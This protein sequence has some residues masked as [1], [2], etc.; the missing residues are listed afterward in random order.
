M[1]G[2]SAKTK[3]VSEPKQLSPKNHNQP[4]RGAGSFVRSR[5]SNFKRDG[6]DIDCQLGKRESGIFFNVLSVLS[7]DLHP[8]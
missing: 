5:S 4:F 6:E 8:Y 7:S 2:F 3:S 1:N